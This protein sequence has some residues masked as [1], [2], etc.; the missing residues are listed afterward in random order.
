[1]PANG[2]KRKGA[3]MAITIA[4]ALY[5]AKGNPSK[6]SIALLSAAMG[7]CVFY[8]LSS[9]ALRKGLSPAEVIGRL[10]V[11]V[12][13]V[14]FGA[15][16][17]GWQFWPA[18]PTLSMQCDTAFLPIV[19]APHEKASVLLLSTKPRWITEHNPG[20]REFKWPDEQVQ[21]EIAYSCG[22]TDHDAPVLEDIVIPLQVHIGQKS[23]TEEIRASLFNQQ[24]M[25][26]YVV[27]QCAT[28]ADAI[29]PDTV[30]A[31]METGGNREEIPLRGQPPSSLGKIMFFFPS[32]FTWMDRPTCD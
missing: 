10:L 9:W 30:T 1:M 20:E 23:L 17:Y 29:I 12:L 22:L 15:G 26:F 5:G 27:N 11:L 16:F 24:T 19:I 4:L 28:D 3:A 8:A 21:S 6:F 32:N 31:V 2:K 7:G 18:P 25:V 13:L 14:C